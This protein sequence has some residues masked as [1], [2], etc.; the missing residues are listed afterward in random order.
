MELGSWVSLLRWWREL[1]LSWEGFLEEALSTPWSLPPVHTHRLR[2]SGL[3]WWTSCRPILSP[4]AQSPFPLVKQWG[5]GDW[6][7]QP[8]QTR[9]PG[10]V[11]SGGD[12]L[13]CAL[14]LAGRGEPSLEPPVG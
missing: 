3:W 8:S 5:L 7:S 6:G 11:A 1:L 2:G 12:R 9:R 4:H 14:W 13:C 10:S